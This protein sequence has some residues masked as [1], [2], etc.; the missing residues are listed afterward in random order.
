MSALSMPLISGKFSKLNTMN[1]IHRVKVQI[2]NMSAAASRRLCY[3]NTCLLSSDTYYQELLW[4]F[5][6]Q[7]QELLWLLQHYT[8]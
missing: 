4:Q 8:I 6:I 1:Q 5:N 7:N 2:Y 3:I